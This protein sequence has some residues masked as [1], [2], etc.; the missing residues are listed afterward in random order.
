MKKIVL[1]TNVIISAA[2]T[3]GGNPAKIINLI[4]EKEIQIY[5]CAD[6]VA[7]YREVLSRERFSI[8][9]AED[10]IISPYQYLEQ[11]SEHNS[12]LLS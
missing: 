3:P 9:S 4:A 10:F 1:D 7:K 8:P 2:L 11:Y 12:E 5:Y 6:I